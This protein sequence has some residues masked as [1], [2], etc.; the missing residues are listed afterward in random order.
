MKQ[1]TIIIG[2]LAGIG[3]AAILALVLAAGWIVTQ[4]ARMG[5][6]GGPV[7]SP[8]V[9]T[10]EISQ[11]HEDYA[12]ARKSF[13]TKLL[14][15]GPSPQ[16]VTEEARIPA[17]VQKIMYTSGNLQLAAYV[18]GPPPD[19]KKRPAV[20][21]LHGGFAFGGDDLEMPQHFRDAGYVVMV[22]VLR[23]ENGQPGNFT[24]Y[25]D[26]VDDVLAAAEALAGLPYVDA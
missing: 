13:Q 7:W 22:P 4:V 21:F 15:T 2:L 12:E 5:A 24:L 3:G 25:Y 16:P 17:G 14:Q 11:R 23:G 10:T 26:E 18:D 20:L 9:P 8:P 19:G 6:G 1:S